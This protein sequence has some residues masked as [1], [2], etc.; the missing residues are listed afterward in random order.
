MRFRKVMSVSLS[1]KE[2]KRLS[3][4]CSF[5]YAISII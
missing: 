1:M 5:D 2:K 4:V 3:N